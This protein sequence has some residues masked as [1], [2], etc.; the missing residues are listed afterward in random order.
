M[1][2]TAAYR[3]MLRIRVLEEKI[4]ACADRDEI[5]GFVHPY[6]GQEAVA[7]GVLAARRP[8]EW[9]VSFYRCHGHAVAAGVPLDGIVREILGRAGGLCGGKGGS[10]HLA[11]RA[12]RFLGASSIVGSQLAV[13]AGVAM[14]ERSAGRAAVVFCGDGALGAGVAFETL[15]ICATLG[16]P[17]L[18]VCEDN[19]WQDQTRSDLVRHRPP[20][21]LV[22]GLGIEPLAV[23]GNDVA[24]VHDA[25]TTALARCRR[26][27]RPQV[28]VARTYL[29]HYH[30][31]VGGARPA[32]YRPADEVAYW[33]ARDPLDVAAARLGLGDDRR[34]RWHDAAVREIDQVFAV[35]SAA[36]PPD[37]T[38]ATANVTSA[39]PPPTTAPTAPAV[40]APTA[41]AVAAPAAG[42]PTVGR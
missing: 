17:L 18:V 10:M 12:R 19:G 28:L 21:E 41:P 24:A 31:Q 23:D 6:T 4:I 2:L 26:E 15:T 25:A 13:A 34:A 1:R 16:L 42:S 32:E 11:D 29:R 9:V 22:A 3:T 20:V 40:A 5:V 36:P 33:H 7:A 35:A 27:R 14:A 38:T 8:D 39:L 30:A 37:P